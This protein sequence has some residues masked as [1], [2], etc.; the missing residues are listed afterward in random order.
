MA[1]WVES[2]VVRTRALAVRMTVAEEEVVVVPED[3]EM[4]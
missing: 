4:F 3:R 2:V 1:T